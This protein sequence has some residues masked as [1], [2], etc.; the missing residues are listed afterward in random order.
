MSWIC[1]CVGPVLFKTG[2]TCTSSSVIFKTGI[3]HNSY[4]PKRFLHSINQQG[5]FIKYQFKKT[6]HQFSPLRWQ[7]IERCLGTAVN[8]TNQR[9]KSYFNINWFELNCQESNHTFLIL[10]N[11]IGLL[12]LH[13]FECFNSGISPINCVCLEFAHCQPLTRGFCWDSCSAPFGLCLFLLQLCFCSG[14]IL[15]RFCWWLHGGDFC[16]GTCS[17]QL[18][19]CL[20][21]Q[22]GV[23]RALHFVLSCKR[24]PLGNARHNIA[25]QLQKRCLWLISMMELWHYV[26][27][28]TCN[29]ADTNGQN[30]QLLPT[31]CFYLFGL[32]IL[33]PWWT[34]HR[35]LCWL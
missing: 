5:L 22:I 1:V 12:I 8:L 33:F 16:C 6:F 34:N 20:F 7:W 21:H 15:H 26:G 4:L 32:I 2:I 23:M 13:G 10:F 29:N 9:S 3:S 25:C 35:P 18:G 30:L 19:F 27:W 28:W 11:I 24:E 14:F 31:R 17:A